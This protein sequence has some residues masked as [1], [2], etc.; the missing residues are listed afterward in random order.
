[1]HST[2]TALKWHLRLRSCFQCL[3]HP[4]TLKQLMMCTY[5]QCL[6]MWRWSL[7]FLP[8]F[9]VNSV[10]CMIVGIGTILFCT[11][12]LHSHLDSP[13][14]SFSLFIM[15]ITNSD[16]QKE[17][18]SF[19]PFSFVLVSALCGKLLSIL[20]ITHSVRICR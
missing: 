5:R 11:S 3:W 14:F 15:F 18:S 10:A 7:F 13:D 16:S 17:L 1:M 8:Y 19:L 2:I 6:C 9:L 20:L 12:Y 4:F